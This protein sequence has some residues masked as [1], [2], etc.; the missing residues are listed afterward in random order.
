[1]AAMYAVYHG[2]EGLTRIARR[3]HR[4]ATILAGAVRGV[5]AH[6]GDNFFDTLHVGNI[7]AATVHAN[8]RNSRI[9]L[10]TVDDAH[11][12]I[13]LD[14]TTTRED[15]IAIAGL[16][17]AEIGDIDALDREAGDALPTALR[18]Q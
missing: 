8:A 11:L 6:V 9:N 14:E 3:T 15:V 18:R 1:M 16:F 13:S 7:D 5:G 10:R 4:L 12:C 2:P 17:G